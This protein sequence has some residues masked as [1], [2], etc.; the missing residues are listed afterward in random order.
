M[1][2]VFNKIDLRYLKFLVDAELI[3]NWSSLANCDNLH[4]LRYDWSN[5]ALIHVLHPHV[6]L[7]LL[8]AVLIF[9]GARTVDGKLYIGY[10]SLRKYTPKNIKTTSTRYNITRGCKTCI[11]VSYTD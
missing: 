2:L 8:L 9:F 4:L 11:N 7:S 6:I 1:I 3:Y 5:M 10:T